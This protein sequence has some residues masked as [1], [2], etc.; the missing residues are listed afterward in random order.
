MRLWSLAG[1]EEVLGDLC[2]VDRLDSR[3]HERGHT[4]SFACW[5]WTTDVTRIPT[6][7][8][9]WRAAR[10]AG[11]VEAMLGFSPPSRQVAPPPGIRCRELLV[12][13]D[14]IKDWTPPHA[15]VLPLAPKR[16]PLVGVGR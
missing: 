14:K 12:H 5:V 7:C 2:I 16:T 10:G 8:E 15:A 4:K 3:T 1:A 11:R 9:I 13:I 6:K